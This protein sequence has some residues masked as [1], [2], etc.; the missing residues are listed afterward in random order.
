ML[1]VLLKV[2]SVVAK[3]LDPWPKIKLPSHQLTHCATASSGSMHLST[4]KIQREV[5][6]SS[7]KIRSFGPNTKCNSVVKSGSTCCTHPPDRT[8]TKTKTNIHLPAGRTFWPPCSS[9]NNRLLRE[10]VSVAIRAR[11]ATP[12]ANRAHNS[13]ARARLLRQY[14]ATAR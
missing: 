1:T 13:C 6:K 12:H 14:H 11:R 9:L 7:S 4:R 5:P 8:M 10:S 3:P 2:T